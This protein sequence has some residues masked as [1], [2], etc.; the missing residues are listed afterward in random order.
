[1]LRYFLCAFAILHLSVAIAK[2]PLVSW[3][4]GTAKAAIVQFVTAV[5]DEK[6]PGFVPVAERIAVFDMDGTLINEKPA[7]LQASF[8][9]F[10]VDDAIFKNP[11]FEK[12]PDVRKLISRQGWKEYFDTVPWAS[13]LKVFAATHTGMSQTLFS[14]MVKDYMQNNPHYRRN[15]YVPMRELLDYLRAAQFKIYIVTGS[16]NQ[17]VRAFSE[18]YFGIPSEQ[19]IGSSWKTALKEEGDMLSIQRLPEMA[20]SNDKENKVLAIDL[21]IGRKPIFAAGNDGNAGDIAMLRYTTQPGKRSGFGLIV[22]HDDEKRESVYTDKNGATLAAAQKY[23]WTVVHVKE[24][25]KRLYLT[26]EEANNRALT[27]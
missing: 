22:T 4:E 26:A 18:D 3:N 8:L 11:V 2:E 5:S 24:D 6:N 10:L 25:W 21:H 20:H 17:F 19:V 13:T 16:E 14:A 27:H 9:D 12:D 23:R 1:M 15:I 7:F